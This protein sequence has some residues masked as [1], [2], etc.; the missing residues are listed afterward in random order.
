MTFLVLK[1]EC[2]KFKD[3]SDDKL[4]VE[5]KKHSLFQCTQ[6]QGVQR[7]CD[8]AWFPISD[9]EKEHSKSHSPTEPPPATGL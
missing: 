8:H 2:L 9:A 5:F 1:V 6:Y 7:I 3:V 4:Y